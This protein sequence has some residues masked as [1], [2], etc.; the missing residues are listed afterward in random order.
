MTLPA[1]GEP[2]TDDDDDPTTLLARAEQLLI[3]ADEQLAAGDLGA[4]QARVDEAGMLVA[5]AYDLLSA[6]D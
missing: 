4:Y 1:T 3:E 5:R 6:T 2:S